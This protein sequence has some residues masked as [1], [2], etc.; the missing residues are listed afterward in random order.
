MA[1]I[2]FEIKDKLGVISES[3]K[4]WTKELNII[5][6]NGKQAKYDLRDWAPEHEKMGKGVTLSAEELKS[7]KEI[8]NNMDL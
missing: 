6:W 7:L 8:L 3:P 2:K 4:G 1:D 5:S